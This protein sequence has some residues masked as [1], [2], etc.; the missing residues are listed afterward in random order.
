MSELKDILTTAQEIVADTYDEQEASE[1]FKQ[2]ISLTEKMPLQH[3]T[4]MDIECLLA[5][6]ISIM[7]NSWVKKYINLEAMQENYDLESV[8]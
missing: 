2:I 4:M 6:L 7:P 8:D 1:A 3:K 5:E